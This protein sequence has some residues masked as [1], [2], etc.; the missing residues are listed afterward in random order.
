METLKLIPPLKGDWITRKTV[1]RQRRRGASAV[2]LFL[3]MI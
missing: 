3:Q 1:N 2:N